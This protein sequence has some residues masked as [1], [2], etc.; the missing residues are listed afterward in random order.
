M[1]KILSLILAGLMTLS[2]AA[3]VA[4][5]DAAVDAAVEQS[6]TAED[7]AIEF[8]ANYGIFK[9][10]SAAE[11][12]AD[13]D[14][15]IQRYQ[16]ALFVSRISTGW[17][18]DAQWEDGPANNSTFE[19]IGE[20]PANKYLGALSYANQNGIIEGYSATKFAPYD[21]ITYRD[22]LTMVV[23]TLGYKGLAYPW[24]YIEKA[25]ELGLTEDVNAAYTDNLTRGQ[26]A[27]IIYNAMFAATKSGET[28][29]KSIFDCDFGWQEIVIVASNEASFDANGLRAAD[30]YVAFKLLKDNGGLGDKTYYVKKAELGLDD[31]HDDELQV[32]AAYIALFTIK[33][34]IATMVDADS[35]NF[36]T[37]YNLGITDNAGE[38]IATLPVQAE[39]ANYN[40]V[41][42]Y[43]KSEIISAPDKHETFVYGADFIN[44]TRE[45]GKRVALEW[46]S[47]NIMQWSDKEGK[48]V[49]AWVYNKDL[50]RYYQYDV[51]TNGV[52]YINWMS[53]KEFEDF[54]KAAIQE[55]LKSYKEYKLLAANE[56]SGTAYSKLRL[57]DVNGDGLAE[58]SLFKTYKIGQIYVDA[59]E[60]ATNKNNV[61]HADGKKY[62]TYKI[63][64]LEGNVQ[65]E[66]FVEKDHKAHEYLKSVNSRTDKDG[67][68]IDGYAWLNVAD[69]V[70]TFYKE[71][72]SFENGSI[73]LYN[74]NQTTGEIEIIKHITAKGAASDDADSY[75]GTGVLK[76][77]S[78]TASEPFVNIDG[79]KLPLGYAKL[80]GAVFGNVSENMA[81]KLLAAKDLDECQM[82]YITYVVVD[83]KVVDIDLRNAT[84]DVL[85]VLG[86][87]GVTSDGYIAVY[88]YNTTDTVAKIYR[89]ASYNAWKKGDYRYYPTN[90]WA[91][92]AFEAGTIYNVTSYDAETNS[93]NV[94]TE[95]TDL[96]AKQ[97]TVYGTFEFDTGYRVISNAEK[98]KRGIIEKMSKDDRYIIVYDNGTIFV[99]NGIVTDDNWK[100]HGK[101]TKVDSG[102]YVIYVEPRLADSTG[103]NTH[104]TVDDVVPCYCNG[105]MSKHH[106]DYVIGFKETAHEIGFVLYDKTLGGTLSA[107]YDEAIGSDWYLLGSTQSEVR[108]TDLLT[109]DTDTCFVSNNIDLVKG[110]VYITL[111]FGGNRM[112]IN[113]WDDEYLEDC[114]HDHHTCAFIDRIKSI[115]CEQQVQDARY[116]VADGL[117]FTKTAPITKLELS[118]KLGLIPYW[119]SDEVKQKYADDMVGSFK[120]FVYDKDHCV[121]LTKLDELAD[122]TYYYGAAIYDVATKK[123]VVYIYSEC[124]L[125]DV[126]KDA[127]ETD[128]V[129][130]FYYDDDKQTVENVINATW[131]GKYESV[132]NLVNGY[133][134]DGE[135]VR[136]GKTT[137]DTILVN[138][139]DLIGSTHADLAKH[140]YLF[141]IW[142]NHGMNN[143]NV[144]N[145]EVK[146]NGQ[147]IVLGDNTKLS[148]VVTP[149]D[150]CSMVEGFE[151]S[152][153][154]IVLK[155]NDT[156]TVKFYLN[157][158]KFESETTDLVYKTNEI[159]ITIEFKANAEG[160]VTSEVTELIINGDVQTSNIG[161]DIK[162][163]ANGARYLRGVDFSNLDEIG[164]TYL[165]H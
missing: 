65:Y 95:N 133:G 32:G 163:W 159:T 99:R 100:I 109:G 60:C 157:G 137:I 101:Y 152:N 16:M 73:V 17:V 8:L 72:G 132:R 103:D 9:G 130:G 14:A 87:A 98:G 144:G 69:F 39:L 93:Y 139:N 116:M 3:F 88:A 121:Q 50:D 19:D 110:R 21:G 92:E 44:I 134:P 111:N 115:Y 131:T 156:A 66:Q 140:G 61:N 15:S 96:N 5:D 149:C 71:D 7:Y 31:D 129:I 89:I 77:Y 82:Q 160:V 125:V 123:V 34:D 13:A 12:V 112:I 150:E 42:E 33:D 18:D 80:D 10:T 1:K 45:N 142:D 67:N 58:R 83:G 84:S 158:S 161:K 35:L 124:T 62:P 126:V 141:G 148:A 147:E 40:V 79:E 37:V 97:K 151:L 74:V 38:P 23:R 85:I 43:Q 102:A 136:D 64:D 90:A 155:A 120:Y 146:V 138:F 104:S 118:E 59:K 94:Y 11:L 128:K 51:D 154:G 2:C 54:Y 153:A 55:V 49:T 127:G 4:A 81:K 68:E 117:A 24:G 91:D 143:F 108:V 113:Q 20:E 135:Y 164:V 63:T 47:N 36:K 22:A 41:K 76:A 107:A 122:N 119:S 114:N 30:G 52:L 78:V 25:V 75:I 165:D 48:Y 27:V 162:N 70:T 56:I 105:D 57:F 145:T 86:Y 46:T 6:N 53:D 29:A 106:G 26:V 28:L